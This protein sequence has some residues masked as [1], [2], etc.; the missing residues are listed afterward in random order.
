[1]LQFPNSK[2]GQI[3]TTLIFEEEYLKIFVVYAVLRRRIVLFVS[4]HTP[5]DVS[6]SNI[7]EK[8]K[9]FKLLI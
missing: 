5:F 4:S 6:A 2:R 1:M 9:C 7:G 3:S 8:M